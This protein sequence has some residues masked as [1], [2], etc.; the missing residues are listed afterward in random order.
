M[1]EPRSATCYLT[2]MQ[3]LQLL[4]VIKYM[5]EN[6]FKQQGISHT[7]ARCRRHELSQFL[8]V[9]CREGILYL[10]KHAV[11]RV[12]QFNFQTLSYDQ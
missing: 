11:P 4:A 3:E 8:C 10:V 9:E 6:W 5:T 12:S 7:Y 2:T 1:P